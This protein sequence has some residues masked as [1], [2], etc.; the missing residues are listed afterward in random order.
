MQIHDALISLISNDKR[1]KF[2][3]ITYQL[4]LIPEKA[5]L[6]CLSLITCILFLDTGRF[7]AKITQ[8]IKFR[9]ANSTVTDNVDVIDYRSVQRKDALDADAKADLADGDRFTRAAVFAGDHNALKNLE[10]FLVAFLDAD[11]NL[12]GIARL[13]RGD[14]F[15][16]LCCFY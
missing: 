5:L 4:S 8:V 13:E 15:P 14:I 3:L 16:Q 7:A 10:T 9:S 2:S 6:R 12:D 11:V 1:L